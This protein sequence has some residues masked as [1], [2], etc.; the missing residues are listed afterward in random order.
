MHLKKINSESIGLLL[1][2]LQNNAN[3]FPPLFKYITWIWKCV[4]PLYKDAL[5]GKWTRGFN[6]RYR[7]SERDLRY[8]LCV[9]G[10]TLCFQVMRMTYA[11]VNTVGNGSDLN[12]G[13]FIQVTCKLCKERVS[14]SECLLCHLQAK[15][16]NKSTL[17]C[18]IWGRVE[19]FRA[20]VT[21]NAL[22]IG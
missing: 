20:T 9:C 2:L 14:G 4:A 17:P 7:G 13:L 12:H 1:F 6:I 11:K 15:I 10:E 18:Y 16:G 5:T 19:Y 8:Y 21:H 3:V 22:L